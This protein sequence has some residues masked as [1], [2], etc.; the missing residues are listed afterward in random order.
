M[1]LWNKTPHNL[2]LPSLF[3]FIFHFHLSFNKVSV[4]AAPVCSLASP[5]L[6]WLHIFS[7]PKHQQGLCIYLV[8]AGEEVA[9]VKQPQSRRGKKIWFTVP[10]TMEHII[11]F[12]FVFKADSKGVKRKSH[13]RST[14]FVWATDLQPLFKYFIGLNA[15]YRGKDLL[16]ASIN[17]D[18]RRESVTSENPAK[19]EDVIW[20]PLPPAALAT[21]V[22]ADA[23]QNQIQS[24]HNGSGNVGKKCAFGF[25]MTQLRKGGYTLALREVDNWKNCLCNNLDNGKCRTSHEGS[26]VLMFFFGI[27]P[28]W[29]QRSPR[30]T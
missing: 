2:P 9:V 8:A 5:L 1:K 26:T 23:I 21:T 30:R 11:L 10:G 18:N 29:S 27:Q 16:A 24:W 7:H 28:R 6:S 22:A 15:T 17:Q 12:C 20:G 13:Q 14:V 25:S 19:S 4:Y 3:S